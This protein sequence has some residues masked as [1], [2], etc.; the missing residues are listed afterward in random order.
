MLLTVQILCPMRFDRFL[1]MIPQCISMFLICCLFT[2]L[3]SIYTP[4]YV[5]AGTTKP[6]SIKLSTV[7]LQ[8]LMY[9]AIFPLTQSLTLL[10]LGVEM[11]GRLLG[12]PAGIPVLLLLTL[13]ECAVVLV[14]YYFLVAWQGTLFQGRE[15]KILDVVTSRAL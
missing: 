6:S 7:L 4:I 14:V 8:L 5:A 13:L 2:N 3:M 15:L 12:W 9:M 1:A 11:L 10:P